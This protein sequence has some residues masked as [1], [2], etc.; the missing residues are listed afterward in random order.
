[1]G[2]ARILEMERGAVGGTEGG[3]SPTGVPPTAV[4][5]AVARETPA[6]G[7]EEPIPDPAVPEKPVRRRFTGEYKLRILR[8]TDQCTQLGQLGALLRRE[9][10]YSSHLT[11]WRQQRDAGTLA[12][13]A[14]K[15]RGRKASPDAPWI[16]DNDRLRRENHRLAAKL[17]QAETIIEVQ[18]KLSELLGIPL[19]APESNERIP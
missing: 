16:A 17:R 10:L 19:P 8:E 9:G 14:P 13:L 18:K 7:N 5:A 3:R 15:R 2:K 6:A 1:M 4:A 11:T 12:G